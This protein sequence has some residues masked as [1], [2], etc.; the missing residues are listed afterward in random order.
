VIL[1]V[2]LMVCASVCNWRA[3]QRYNSFFTYVLNIAAINGVRIHV[4]MT[5]LASTA[6]DIVA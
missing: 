4:R 2:C 5:V 1:S 3:R 6:G